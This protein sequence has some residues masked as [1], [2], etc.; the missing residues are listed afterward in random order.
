[1]G[2][3]SIEEGIEHAGRGTPPSARS[4]VARLKVRSV[5]IL[6]VAVCLSMSAIV[7]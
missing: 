4:A 5:V 6:L 2:P 7:I 3:P 1:M